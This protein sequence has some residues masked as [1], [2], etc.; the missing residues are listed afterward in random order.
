M[1]TRE[2]KLSKAAI[3]I[4]AENQPDL[5]L[6]TLMQLLSQLNVV[7][8]HAYADWRNPSLK[9]LVK[10]LHNLGFELH[11]TWSGP[12]LGDRKNEADQQMAKGIQRVV[13]RDPHIETIV[14]ISGDHFFTRTVQRL[15]QSGKYVIVAAT[16][17]RVS[18]TLCNAADRYLPLGKV[19]C[20]IQS[21]NQV[22][23]TNQYMT[24]RFAVQKSGVRPSNLEAL[25]RQGIVI[26]ERKTSPQ[27]GE[28]QEIYL[29]REAYAVQATL[30]FAT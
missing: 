20:W 16:P 30:G 5:N 7:E 22:E 6:D 11:H 1:A 24:F 17:R 10:E 18:K 28:R 15:R 25:I 21:L 9:H 27:W 8:R 2:T 23:N 26:Q 29:N 14:I 12:Q 4:D 13:E 3:F 19:A